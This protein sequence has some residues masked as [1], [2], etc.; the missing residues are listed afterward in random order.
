MQTTDFMTIQEVSQYADKSIQT[1]RYWIKNKKDFPK[2]RTILGKKVFLR[3]DI[4]NY[5]F[6]DERYAG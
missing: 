1:L 6:T 2:R 5:H 4:E 3:I